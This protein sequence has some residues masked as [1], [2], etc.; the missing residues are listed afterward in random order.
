MKT[1]FIYGFYA[2]ERLSEK[3]AVNE[4]MWKLSVESDRS[5]MTTQ[6]EASR[7]T[8]ARLQHNS[9]PAPLL[10]HTN[11]ANS[12]LFYFFNSSF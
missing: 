5:Q 12:S 8:K 1:T 10:H 6:Y 9:P 11:A 7:I 4:I 3:R 2:Q